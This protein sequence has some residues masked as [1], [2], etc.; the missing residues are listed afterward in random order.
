MGSSRDPRSLNASVDYARNFNK[1][2]HSYLVLRRR[3]GCGLRSGRAW[4]PS[5]GPDKEQEG[6][7]QV[8]DPRA[9]LCSNQRC[10]LAHE[11]VHD[12]RDS[13]QYPKSAASCAYTAVVHF[14]RKVSWW[15]VVD[16]GLKPQ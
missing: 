4:I 8:A 3:V 2:L 15:I 13:P 16:P 11:A 12:V 10:D 9:E 6:G 1:W 5:Q 14:R 7:A